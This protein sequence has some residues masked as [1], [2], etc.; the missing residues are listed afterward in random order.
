M[1]KLIYCKGCQCGSCNSCSKEPSLH[2]EYICDKC[3]TNLNQGIP[4]TVSFG[5]GSSLDG[6]EYHFC[7]LKCL[8]DFTNAELQKENK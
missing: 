3:G 2:E 8:A 7:N 5:Y 4:I 6:T 1:K